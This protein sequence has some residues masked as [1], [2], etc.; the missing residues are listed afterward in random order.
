M[1]LLKELKKEKTRK[2]E[3]ENSEK[4]CW[5]LYADTRSSYVKGD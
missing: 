5:K 3:E 2:E 4:G 1:E